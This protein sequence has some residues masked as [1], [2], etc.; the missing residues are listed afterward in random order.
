MFIYVGISYRSIPAFSALSGPSLQ[1]MMGI[2]LGLLSTAGLHSMHSIFTLSHPFSSVFFFFFPHSFSIQWPYEIVYRDTTM[3]HVIVHLLSELSNTPP[4]RDIHIHI[5]N[6]LAMDMPGCPSWPHKCHINP[7]AHISCDWEVQNHAMIFKC[8]NQY[9]ISPTLFF[10]IFMLLAHA[11]K[12][13]YCENFL[14]IF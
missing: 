9:I 12:K 2:R 7:L 11:L 10:R 5:H 6:V 13:A 1:C 14:K 4:H 3:S 8:A